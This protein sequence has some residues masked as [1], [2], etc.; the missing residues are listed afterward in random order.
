MDHL[1]PPTAA[2]PTLGLSLSLSLSLC[3]PE[4]RGKTDM[5]LRVL[6]FMRRWGRYGVVLA[7]AAA[8]LLYRAMR[9]KRNTLRVSAPVNSS[10]Q[11]AAN[12]TVIR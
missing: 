3:V 6:S 8:A 10:L 1:R 7:V 4:W 12:L 5:Q 11:L 2:P 9:R